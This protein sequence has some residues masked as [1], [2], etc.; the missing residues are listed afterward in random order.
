MSPER[1]GENLGDLLLR[2]GL[3]SNDALEEAL[4]RQRETNRPLT[5]ILVE[6]NAITEQV[7][8]NFLKGRLGHDVLSLKEINIPE[9]LFTFY[10][11]SM[12]ERMRAV[13]CK[14]DGET[15]VIAMEDPSDLDA[16]DSLKARIGMR[17]QPVIATGSDIELVLARWPKMEEETDDETVAP[18]APTLIQRAVKSL[19]FPV[20][21]FAPLVAMICMLLLSDT[22]QRNLTHAPWG[23]EP[24]EAIFS[25]MLIWGI[26]SLLIYEI[27]GIFVNPDHRA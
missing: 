12:A 5:S 26:W 25:L 1:T 18:A 21:A 10:P 15:I 22:F 20:V 2:D 7:K 23:L 24:W 4:R 17:V 14:L 3:V 19:F 8:M 13:P 11:R 6:M 27:D 9:I 16:V